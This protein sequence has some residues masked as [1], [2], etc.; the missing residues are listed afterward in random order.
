MPLDAQAQA[1]LEAVAD[2]PPYH[3][4]PV[5]E[6]RRA[7]EAGVGAMGGPADK[8]ESVEDQRL[9]RPGGEL[10]VRI[11][12]PAGA[13]S[14]TL[15]YF[16]GGGW[17]IGSLETHDRVCRRLARSAGCR[18]VSVDYRLA[19]EHPYPAALIDAWAASAWAIHTAEGPV[20]VG[21]DSAGGNLAAV[22]ALRARDRGF[23]LALQLLLYPV[24][25]AAMDTESYRA[26]ADG[27]RLTRAAMAWYWELYLAGA[28]PAD[29]EA[30]PLRA[31]DLSGVA[32]AFVATAEYDP[33]RDE[34]EAY[35][36]RLQEAGVAVT[37][38][39]YVGLIHG[40]YTLG[41][42]LDRTAPAIDEAAAALRAALA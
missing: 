39:R 37:A 38:R 32:P 26:L 19:P 6:A 11:Y 17:V 21:G 13:G 31:P 24:T 5:A 18:V 23:P 12:E 4:L 20:A 35:A 22:V 7:Y 25:D 34:G 41:G 3:T 42:V 27:Y 1:Y 2:A 33:L 9:P 10:P 29:P 8:I 36:R 28:D 16:H 30:S 15:V 14:G 40:F